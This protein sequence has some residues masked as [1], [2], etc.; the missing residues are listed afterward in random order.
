MR[1]GMRHEATGNSKKIQFFGFTLC[2]MFFALCFSA[3]AQQSGKVPRIGVLWPTAPPD[4]LFDAF[5]QGLGELGYVQGQNIA[6][7]ERWAEGKLE[8]LPYLSCRASSCRR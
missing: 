7:D 8:R 1:M 5:K 2:A 4:P 6:F 3:E